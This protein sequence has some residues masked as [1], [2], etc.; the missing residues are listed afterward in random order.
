MLLAQLLVFTA[1]ALALLI[2]KALATGVHRV[3]QSE[4][5]WAY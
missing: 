3:G 5:P 2:L 1:A 4:G